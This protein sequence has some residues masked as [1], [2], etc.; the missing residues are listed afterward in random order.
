MPTNQQGHLPK[1]EGAITQQSG[2][3]S[4]GSRGTPDASSTTIRR[5]EPIRGNPK[6]LRQVNLMTSML[7]L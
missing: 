6:E 1:P 2:Y 4:A 5:D 3:T 7:A